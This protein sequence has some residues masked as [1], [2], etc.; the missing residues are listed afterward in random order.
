MIISL[1]WIHVAERRRMGKDV[2]TTMKGQKK[3]QS[4]E[5]ETKQKVELSYKI[6]KAL[7]DY[8]LWIERY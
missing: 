7:K 2:G 5:K 8:V 3:R 6:A 1:V 4:F